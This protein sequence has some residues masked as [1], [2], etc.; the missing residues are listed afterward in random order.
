MLGLRMEGLSGALRHDFWV[1]TVHLRGRPLLLNTL[2]TCTV[3][4]LTVL[5][6]HVCRVGKLALHTD[7]DVTIS[8]KH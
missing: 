7:D 8:L 1:G 2:L 3:E 6:A 5:E 4:M